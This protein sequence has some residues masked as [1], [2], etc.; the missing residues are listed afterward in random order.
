MATLN[1]KSLARIAAIQAMYQLSG[2]DNLDNLSKIKSQI[3]DYYKS[4]NIYED[5]DIE[6]GD[7][8]IKVSSSL[9]NK[10][11]DTILNN[12]DEIDKIIKEN[13]DKE[14]SFE[15]LP[16]NSKSILRSGAAEI[17]FMPEIP[18][19]V[20]V[21][22]YTNIASSMLKETEIGLVNSVLDSMKDSR[23]KE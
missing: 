12:I 19:V 14:S 18:N 3:L 15:N 23:K 11:L 1:S 20:V 21:S 16:E 13:L 8:K 22:E 4:S 10:L 17:I 7:T 5:L 6:E 2:M 9:F